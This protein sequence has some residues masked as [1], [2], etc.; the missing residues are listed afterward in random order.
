MKT[1]VSWL[2]THLDTTAPLGELVERLVMLGHDVDGVDDPAKALA[3]FKVAR[4]VSAEPHPNADRLRV[5]VIDAGPEVNG[6]V[7]G[8]AEVQ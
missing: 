3:G 5:C 8:G 6:D 1:T 7:N 4:V 2:K